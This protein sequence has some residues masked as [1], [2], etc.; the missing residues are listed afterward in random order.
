MLRVCLICRMLFTKIEYFEL[1]QTAPHRSVGSDGPPGWLRAA[2]DGSERPIQ[3]A[4]GGC[5]RLRAAPNG[6]ERPIK[7]A[8]GGS[9][10]PRAAPDGSRRR[11]VGPIYYYLFYTCSFFISFCCTRVIFG[12]RFNSEL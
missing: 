6:F 2:L 11:L 10:R 12:F 9:R 3:P 8:V 1:F 5:R 7:S 4:L